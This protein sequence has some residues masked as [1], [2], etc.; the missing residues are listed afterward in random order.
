MT[1]RMWTY[2]DVAAT[3]SP[4]AARWPRRSSSRLGATTRHTADAA[5]AC[6]LPSGSSG[7]RF[8]Y[9]DR[10]VVGPD[11]GNVVLDAVALDSNLRPLLTK[12]QP[13]ASLAM[14]SASSAGLPQRPLLA[15]HR[16]GGLGQGRAGPRRCRPACALPLIADAH[17]RPPHALAAPRSSRPRRLRVGGRRRRRRALGPGAAA[18]RRGSSAA[19]SPLGPDHHRVLAAC[20]T[21]RRAPRTRRPTSTTCAPRW[22]RALPAE[23]SGAA[24]ETSPAWPFRRCTRSSRRLVLTGACGFISCG[25]VR[26]FCVVS[27]LHAATTPVSLLLRCLKSAESNCPRTLNAGLVPCESCF[28]FQYQVLTFL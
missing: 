12:R 10:F 3:S 18:R 15:A 11:G 24:M 26:W 16:R 1:P 25:T 13:T 5:S 21:W 27:L 6:R 8:Y 19:A 2:L 20:A 28:C 23:V 17:A 4:R 14:P 22:R 9:L 7:F